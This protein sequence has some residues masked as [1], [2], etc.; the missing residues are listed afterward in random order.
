[1]SLCESE[2]VHV[3]SM[4]GSYIYMCIGHTHMMGGV[5]VRESCHNA[6]TQLVHNSIV[7][8]MYDHARCIRSSA[9][10]GRI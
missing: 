5:A 1:M 4:H 8:G 10:F 6:S 2:I 9:V 7:H 3:C